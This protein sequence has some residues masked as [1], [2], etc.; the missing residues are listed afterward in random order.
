MQQFEVYDVKQF[1]NHS[2]QDLTTVNAIKFTYSETKTS[3]ESNYIG[4]I[5]GE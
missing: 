1:Q 3:S 2:T 4:T 5:A